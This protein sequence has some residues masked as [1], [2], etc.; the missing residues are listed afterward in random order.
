MPTVFIDARLV[1]THPMMRAKGPME[2]NDTKARWREP[3]V[4]TEPVNRVVALR[5]I[6]AAQYAMYVL[7]YMYVLRP[8]PRCG[9]VGSDG[10]PFVLYIHP[11][12]PASQRPMP[13][14][15]GH[16]LLFSPT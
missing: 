12:H 15:G 10:G 3:P 13:G 9:P 2:E 7:M 6:M 16:L 8:R 14:R 11:S 4:S 5:C 1:L